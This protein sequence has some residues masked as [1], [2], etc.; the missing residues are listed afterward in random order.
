M[1]FGLRKGTP[2]EV[3]RVSKLDSESG[4]LLSLDFLVVANDL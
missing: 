3:Q 4:D 1:T 2:R